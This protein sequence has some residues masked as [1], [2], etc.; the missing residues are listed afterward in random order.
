MDD[1]ITEIEEETSRLRK[2]FTNFLNNDCCQDIQGQ[3]NNGRWLRGQMLSLFYR[4]QNI[5]DIFEAYFEN[6][7]VE[8][9]AMETE[10]K[11]IKYAEEH[12]DK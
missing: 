5:K 9:N 12:K 10:E 1:G 6:R 11:A 3:N 7:L 4:V 8:I 2:T